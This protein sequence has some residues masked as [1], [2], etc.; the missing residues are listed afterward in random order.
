MQSTIEKTT[1]LEMENWCNAPALW[2]KVIPYN[3]DTIKQ[4]LKPSPP[5][6]RRR[7]EEEDENELPRWLQS[8]D[9]LTADELA[10]RREAELDAREA[11]LAEGEKEYEP[12]M[13]FN[14][15]TTWAYLN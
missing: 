5:M 3:N 13:Y 7:L 15:T 10:M 8:N 11:A 2:D 4:Y 6:Q 12:T 14:I 9:E 1:N